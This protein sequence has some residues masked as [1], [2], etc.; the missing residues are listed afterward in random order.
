M[1]GIGWG[2]LLNLGNHSA[3]DICDDKRYRRC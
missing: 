2:P 1:D 3:K